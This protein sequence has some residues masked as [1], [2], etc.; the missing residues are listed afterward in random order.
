[1]CL[2]YLKNSQYM[3]T[4]VLLYKAGKY[5][6]LWPH[7]ISDGIMPMSWLF[8][9]GGQS[10]EASALVL[11]M[12]I[13]DW[14]TSVLT[15]LILQS[16]GLSRVFSSNKF[17]SIISEALGLC[18]DPT[19]TSV[20]GYWKTIVLTLGTFVVKVI[21]LLSNMLSSFVIAFLPRKKWTEAKWSHSV[22]SDSLRSHGL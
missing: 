1:M 15:G 3:A 7:K 16:K 18:Y 14:F 4:A 17:K 13:Q 19:L 11:S 12:N 5:Y 20:C 8:V 10:I 21:S 6:S 9:S 22:M 2:R